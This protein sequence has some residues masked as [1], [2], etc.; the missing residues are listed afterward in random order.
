MY[1]FTVFYGYWISLLFGWWKFGYDRK[2]NC[3][4]DY[5][6]VKLYYM[7]KYLTKEKKQHTYKDIYE[8]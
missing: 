6:I 4:K 3:V 5:N 8:T 7:T 1:L 2:K